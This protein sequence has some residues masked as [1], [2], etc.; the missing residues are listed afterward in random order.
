MDGEGEGSTCL[1]Q[2]EYLNNFSDQ[3]KVPL[4][5]RNISTEEYLLHELKVK[6]EHLQVLPEIFIVN[7]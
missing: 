4:V 3:C 6:E 7:D 2:A 1:L 5:T